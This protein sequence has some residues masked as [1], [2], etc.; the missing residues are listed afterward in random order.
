MG[1]CI[2][3]PSSLNAALSSHYM[4]LY[5]L[6]FAAAASIHCVLSRTN[7]IVIVIVRSRSR[8]NERRTSHSKFDHTILCLCLCNSYE[9]KERDV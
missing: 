5:S 2:T 6:K 1:I 7:V 8:T 4:A 3:S 9:Y